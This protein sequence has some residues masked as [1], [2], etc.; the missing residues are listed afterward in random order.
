ML[1]QEPLRHH[2]TMRI[3]GPADFYF[4]AYDAHQ[5]VEALKAAHELELPHFLLGGGSNAL[6][7]DEGFRG[8]VVRNAIEGVEF[9]GTAV[10][11]GCGTDFL[12]LI[13]ECRDRN[14]SG[15]EF[16]PIQASA[17]HSTERRTLRQD[18]DVHHSDDIFAH[19]VRR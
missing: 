17:A 12:D 6:V 9:D 18:M 1:T 4:A 10:Q 13:Y 16:Q 2:T 11:V 5:L 19:G 15:L 14:L 7:S 8:L 3:G